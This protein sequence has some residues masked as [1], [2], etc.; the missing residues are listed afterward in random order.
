MNKLL[1]AIG[2]GLL[3]SALTPVALAGHNQ[4]V[5]AWRDAPPAYGHRTRAVRVRS[6]EVQHAD[7]EYD[8]ARVL[9]AEPIVRYVT[10]RV[11]QR[12]CW[13]EEVWVDDR[14]HGGTAGATIAGGLI[15][16]VIG[17]QIGGGSGR[18]AMTLVGTL[19]GSAIANDRA[20]AREGG[21]DGYYDTVRRCETRDAVREERR[22]DGYRVT[23]LYNGKEY[24]TRTR[25]DPGDRIR[26]RVSVRP[27]G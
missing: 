15:G 24:T 17:R 14:R 8:Y 4:G 1:V 7:S 9:D 23:Y 3:L 27:A 2:S 20:R 5:R 19:V 12:E 6:Y 22:V 21:G 11:P 16:G 18:D 13:D 25:H 26:V 10:V